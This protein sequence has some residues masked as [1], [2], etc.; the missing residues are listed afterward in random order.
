[1]PGDPIQG[2][3]AIVAVV[4]SDLRSHGV[5]GWHVAGGAL[6]VR[7]DAG[8]RAVRCACGGTHILPTEEPAR[9]TLKLCCHRCHTTCEVPLASAGL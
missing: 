9:H 8:E 5:R 7:T 2:M 4:A 6:L 1:M 3:D